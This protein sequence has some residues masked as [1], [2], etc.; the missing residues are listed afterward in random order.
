MP[1]TA[2]PGLVTGAL[3]ML[4]LLV[5]MGS[6]RARRRSRADARRLEGLL[7]AE[8]ARSE[9]ARLDATRRLREAE[10]RLA[11]I[12]D[13]APCALALTRMSDGAYLDANPAWE[14]LFGLDRHAIRH[15]SALELGLWVNLADRQRIY[16]RL[17]DH[18]TILQRE[19]QLNRPSH[20]DV[21]T[22]L[23]SGRLLYI[24]GQDCALWTVMDITELR[25]AQRHIEELNR[26]LEQRVTDRTA[27]LRATL[28]ALHHTQEELVRQDRMAALGSLVAGIAHELNTPIGNSVTIATTLA[29][30][31]REIRDE[32]AAGKLRRSRFDGHLE[33]TLDATGLLMRSL[34]R[35]EELV[36]SFKQVAVD[37]TSEQRRRFELG[38]FLHEMAITLSPMFKNSPY[39]LEITPTEPL[40]LD[41]YPGALGQIFTNLVDN[42]LLHA[43]DGRAR[44]HIRITSRRVGATRVEIRFDDDGNGIPAANLRRIFD[45]FFTTRLGKGGSGLGL[46]IVYNLATGLLGGRIEV[47]STPG[48]GSRFVLTL[49]DTAPQAPAAPPPVPATRL[50]FEAVGPI[51]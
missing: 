8:A 42:A 16:E 22:C 10:A 2:F 43:F 18:D 37:R 46:H 51:I 47:D 19:T 11:A 33:S 45:P 12:F 38:G 6:E 27:E 44:G 50:N 15:R 1:D 21:L 39:A 23:I 34:V 40:E 3:L 14:Q 41:S 49:P 5:L 29:A 25:R 26:T 28:E 32:H 24:D 4:T 13:S 9:A 20:A 17:A 35:A 31:A 7:Q 48:A 30:N 36:R